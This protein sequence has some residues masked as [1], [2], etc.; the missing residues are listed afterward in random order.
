LCLSG[1]A[2]I[3]QAD[4]PPSFRSSSVDAF[5]S[6]DSAVRGFSRRPIRP[7]LPASSLP[8]EGGRSTR[9][10]H[11]PNRAA[12]WRSRRRGFEDSAVERTA[13]SLTA[14]SLQGPWLQNQTFLKSRKTNLGSFSY[15]GRKSLLCFVISCCASACGVKA[16]AK[17]CLR[18]P[19]AP[20]GRRRRPERICVGLER[21]RPCEPRKGDR[22]RWASS[23]HRW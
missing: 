15:P 7:R 18:R 9:A 3:D 14:R 8:F 19:R 4:S 20:A 12:G 21:P 23:A 22:R 5:N 16:E 17:A 6:T 11:S 10:T 2:S 13:M 1:S